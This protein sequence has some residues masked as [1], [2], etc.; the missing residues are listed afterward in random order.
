MMPE[1][2]PNSEEIFFQ[3]LELPEQDRSAFIRAKCQGDEQIREVERLIRAHEMNER[4]SFLAMPSPVPETQGP[5]ASWGLQEAEGTRI[6]RYRL[7]EK[8]GSGGMGDV[9]LAEQEEEMRREVALKIIKL[10]LDTREVI[11]RFEIER[12][13]MAMF[14]HPCITKVYDAGVTQTGRPYFVMELV[15]GNG[16][17]EFA[18]QHQLNLLS[19]LRIFSDVCQAVQH[20]HQKGIIHRDLKPSNILVTSVDGRAIPKV[21]DFGIAKAIQD[22]MTGGQTTITRYTTLM[23]TPQYMSPEQAKWSGSDLDTRSDI[24]SLGAVLYELISGTPPI[25]ADLLRLAT[26][27]QLYDVIHQTIAEPPSERARRKLAESGG[28]PSRFDGLGGLTR[29]VELDWIVM[30]ALSRERSDRYASANELAADIDRFVSAQP[31]LAAP[32][33]RLYPVQLFVRRHRKSLATAC[34][35]LL[36]TITAG[37]TCLWLALDLRRTNQELTK[38]NERLSRQFQELSESRKNLEE[39][40]LTEQYW[41]AILLA[42]SRLETALAPNFMTLTN[43]IQE[44]LK[45]SGA[46][47]EEMVCCYEYDLALLRDIPYAESMKPALGR[48]QEAMDKMESFHN[49]VMSAA[50]ITDSHVH[51]QACR[52]YQERIGPEIRKLTPVFYT[53]ILA[54]YREAFGNRDPRTADALTMLAASL[55]ANGQKEEAMDHLREVLADHPDSPASQTARR[56]LQEIAP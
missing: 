19:R 35:F 52:L 11:A 56:M 9:Y 8:I 53:E 40:L 31:V 17:I 26:P 7:V 45:A 46:A 48:I 2:K 54:R 28:W 15:R 50:G 3:S 27:N 12:Q 10:G 33:S 22:P 39:S 42:R 29:L 21:I 6:G 20:A 14:D 4:D 44:Q 49:G 36:L 55:Y 43:Q 51:T 37:F 1:F 24:Y 41:L 25:G 38:A 13:A 32:P 34:A 5:G 18:D 30:K 23:G 47:P 16:I